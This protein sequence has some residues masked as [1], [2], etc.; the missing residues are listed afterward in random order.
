MAEKAD[1]AEAEAAEAEKAD[2]AE[3]EA[4]EAEKADTAKAEAAEVEKADKAKAGAA[5]AVSLEH[6]SP[7]RA[8]SAPWLA[9]RAPTSLRPHVGTARIRAARMVPAAAP[10]LADGPAQFRL[11]GPLAAYRTAHG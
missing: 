3:A 1:K 4:A 2:T 6:G 8:P 9:W 7:C 5:T 11:R 10:P